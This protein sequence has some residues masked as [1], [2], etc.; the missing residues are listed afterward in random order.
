MRVDQAD[1][2]VV[3]SASF[4][5]QPYVLHPRDWRLRQKIQ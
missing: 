5:G 3:K 1:A 2:V 4:D